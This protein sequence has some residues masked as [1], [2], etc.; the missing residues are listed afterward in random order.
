[1]I[2][3]RLAAW[4]TPTRPY[5]T[6][7]ASLPII[8]NLSLVLSRAWVCGLRTKPINACP[9]IIW[10]LLS[11]YGDYLPRFVRITTDHTRIGTGLVGL[12]VLRIQS[13][14]SLGTINLTQRHEKHQ[15]FAIG[16]LAKTS[17]FLLRVPSPFTLDLLIF[18]FSPPLLA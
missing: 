10:A 17:R 8:H 12:V 4:V 9:N 14:N 5:I 16:P 2:H 6:S 3:L 11:N 13:V 18:H 7:H 15:R 1:M